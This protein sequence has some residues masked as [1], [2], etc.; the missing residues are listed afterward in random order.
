LAT[1]RNDSPGSA[2]VVT[3]SGK[4]QIET[5]ILAAFILLG[6]TTETYRG[7]TGI[8]VCPDFAIS[9]NYGKI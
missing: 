8:D 9:T 5:V 1:S 3:L 7:I 6:K 4:K 2:V